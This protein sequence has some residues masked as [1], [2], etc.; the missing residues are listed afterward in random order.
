[1]CISA[2]TVESTSAFWSVNRSS[3]RFVPLLRLLRLLQL[4]HLHRHTPRGTLWSTLLFSPLCCETTLMMT[5]NWSCVGASVFFLLNPAA[6]ESP[7]GRRV[8][9]WTL[10][11]VACMWWI[12]LQFLERKRGEWVT[13]VTIWTFTVHNHWTQRHKRSQLNPFHWENSY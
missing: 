5:G 13:Y 11:R 4:C 7:A 9:S 3:R 10:T 12:I 8:S 6:H 2:A 1:M